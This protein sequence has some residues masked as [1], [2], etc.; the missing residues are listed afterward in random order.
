VQ[1]I[2]TTLKAEYHVGLWKDYLAQGLLWHSKF[3]DWSEQHRLKRLDIGTPTFTWA[4]V[5]QPILCGTPYADPELE[6]GVSVSLTLEENDEQSL[7][8]ENTETYILKVST[9]LKEVILLPQNLKMSSSPQLMLSGPGNDPA[10]ALETSE[11]DNEECEPTRAVPYLHFIR[12]ASER[13]EFLPPPM[14]E[15]LPNDH[16]FSY[17]WIPDIALDGSINRAWYMCLARYDYMGP[18]AIGFIIVPTDSTRTRWNR[19]GYLNFYTNQITSDG[20]AIQATDQY[21][22]MSAEET[23]KVAQPNPF[24]VNPEEEFME[25]CIV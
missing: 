11:T 19:I 1:S 12:K 10:I 24:L 7:S 16:Q 8:T 23:A 4:S 20:V 17:D 5:K 2:A 25:I 18:G 21:G 15:E 13:P 14:E 6:K 3:R 22:R 9:Q